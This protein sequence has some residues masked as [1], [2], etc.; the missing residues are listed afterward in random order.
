MGEVYLAEDEHLRRKAALKFLA[1]EF[2]SNADHVERFLREAR[3]ASALNHPNICTIYEINAQCESPYIA[4]EFI[5][6]ET[7]STMIRRRRRNVRQTLDIA[8]QVCSALVEAHDAGIVHRDIKPANIIVSSRGQAKILDFG[9]VKLVESESIASA[10]SQQLLTKAGMIVGTA[11]YMSPEQARGQEVDGRSDVW[12]LGVVLYEMLTGELPFSGETS[13]DTLAAIL[14]KTPTP[15]SELVPEISPEL[16][17]IVMK[18]L[19]SNRELRYKSASALLRDLRE[20][21]RKLEFEELQRTGGAEGK[22]EATFIFDK[23]PTE[24]VSRKITT[25]DAGSMGRRTSNLRRDLA[26]IIGRRSEISEVTHLLRDPN[27]Q[28]VT[29]TGIGGTGKTRL[30]HAV[31]E[32]M[33]PEFEDGV[34]MIELSSVTLPELVPTTIAQ[35]LGI[36]D[37]GRPLM[38]TL[39]DHLADKRMLLVLDNFEQIID[40]APQISELLTAGDGVKILVTS[41][42]L[43]RITAE[44]EFVVPPLSPPPDE[45]LASFENIKRNDAVQLFCERAHSADPAFQLTEKNAR[46][47]AEIC[48]RLEGLPLAIELAAARTRVLSP[49]EILSKL[50]NRLRFLTGGA[51]DLPE[52]QRTMQGAIDWSHDLL[53][54]VE[55]VIFR[56]LSVFAGNFSIEA[57]EAVCS[58]ADSNKTVDV[59]DTI[60]SLL[61]KS[62]LLRHEGQDGERRFGMLEVVREYAGS[63]LEAAGEHDAVSRAHAEYFVSL[64]ERAEPFLQAAQTAEWLDRLEDEHDNLRAAMQWSLNNDPTMAVRLAV[65]VR[66]FWLLHSH[67]SEGYRWL[68]AALERGGEPP[69]QL[70]FKLMNGLGLAARFRGDYQTARKAYEEGLAAGREAGDKQGVA[71][72]SRGLGLVAMQQ[73]DARAAQEYFESGLAISRD[74]GDKFGIAISLSFLGD[75]A[76]SEKDFSRA[77]PLFEE[78]LSLFRELDNKSAVSDALNNLASACLKGGDLRVAKQ[79]FAEAANLALDLGNKMTM[80][81]SLDGFAALAVEQGDFASA[82]QLCGAAEALR[83][84]IGYKIEPAEEVFKEDYLAKLRTQMDEASFS[85]AFAR[86]RATPPEAA[87]QLLF[88][89]STAS[90]NL[91]AI[92]NPTFTSGSTAS[93]MD[94]NSIAVMPFAHLSSAADDEYFCD[95]L[96]EEL[97]NALAKVEGLKVAART[98]AFSFKGKNINI[99]EIGRTLNVR[100][101]LEGS[102]RK[103][104]GRLRITV[105]LVNVADGYHLWSERYDREMKD[106]FDIQDEIT[107]AVVDALKSKLLGETEEDNKELAALVE[108]LKHYTSDV[109]AYQLYLQGR[110][111]L[112]KFTTET[113][114]KSLEYF[115]QA[116][117]I[118]ANYALAYA[119]IADAYIMLT[120]MGPLAPSD[121]MP[122]AKEMALKALELDPDLAEAHTSLGMVLQDY[123]YNFAEAE[124]EFRRAIELSPSNPNARQSYAIL[125]TELERHVEAEKQFRKALEVDPLSIV[126]NWIY[127][128]CLFLSRKYDLAIERA[129]RT[130][131]LDPAF[132]VAYLSLAF[133]YQMKGEHEESVEAYA[134]CSEVMGFP[135]NADYIRES[136]KGGWESFVRS[137]TTP[138]PNR[139]L[140]FSSYIVAVFFAVLG[141]ADGAFN[142]LEASFAK[143]ESHIVMMKSD[144]RFDS[145]RVDTRFQAMLSRVGFP[146]E[147]L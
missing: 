31:A 55:K 60:T 71:L 37:R 5:E 139:P 87:I 13:T 137:M 118:D 143:R 42:F 121:A 147:S 80:S 144:P 76:R 68:K 102:V 18:A 9:L 32:A 100:N 110:F 23:A 54:E 141:D 89:K 62:L 109:E 125:L 38:E 108:D 131:D 145:L 106:I 127:S 25:Q 20:L 138:S 107:V 128:F 117:A 86:G 24:V 36:E 136:F 49:S 11:S 103:S 58:V 113:S 116:I 19:R 90:G 132:G 115:N 83:D 39:K 101:V 81:Y 15:P 135:E 73:G 40:A 114:Y 123:E 126:G 64:G 30:A 74:L 133:A 12:S 119:G 50:E 97:I 46:N 111:F 134:R 96:A 41:R 17:G 43:L 22:E 35:P 140:T 98:S 34:Y 129:K 78:S 72:S 120:E 8:A 130:L 48:S 85:Q 14:T 45:L 142:E 1:S 94:V 6:G 91:P 105:Q 92:E 26:P 66:N 79:H 146:T 27:V 63:A 75:L 29:L 84:A 53:E 10:G 7:V 67:L 52:R 88:E 56:R 59:V 2:S 3:A 57:A 95:G 47:V 77:R 82:A 21:I 69:P 122:K 99:S 124:R 4:M 104:G 61:D 70:R 44:R 28:M 16:E 51:R 93:T 112:N 65:S 33:L